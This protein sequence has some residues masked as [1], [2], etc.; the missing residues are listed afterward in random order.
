MGVRAPMLVFPWLPEPARSF[1]TQDVRTNDPGTS[2]GYPA[3]TL[4]LWT[5][6]PFVPDQLMSGSR[7]DPH[8]Q[9]RPILHL[10]LGG[11]SESLLRKP[12]SLSKEVKA[13]ET[14]VGAIFAPTGCPQ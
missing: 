14:A 9:R 12:V 8:P 6:F 4:S 13:L 2:A 3:Q 7:F 11:R 10:I 1:W 5:S